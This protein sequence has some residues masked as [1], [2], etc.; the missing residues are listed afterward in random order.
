MVTD[1]ALSACSVSSLHCRSLQQVTE[2]C[3]EVVSRQHLAVVG[4]G[5][6]DIVKSSRKNSESSWIPYFDRLDY[7]FDDPRSQRFNALD[8][9]FFRVHRVDAGEGLSDLSTLRGRCM[10]KL[11][12]YAE[13]DM[14]FYG[15]TCDWCKQWMTQT[16]IIELCE[17]LPLSNEGVLDV[18]QSDG[19]EAGNDYFDELLSPQPG[20]GVFDA[21][22]T[23]SRYEISAETQQDSSEFT[24]VP[25][26]DAASPS[27]ASDH[28]DEN[29]GN[30][31]DDKEGSSVRIDPTISSPRPETETKS[32]K[33]E[34][35]LSKFH[36]LTR[37][38][39]RQHF[40]HR[41]SKARNQ[42]HNL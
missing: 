29:H 39:R 27:P 19:S 25:E 13:G 22:P 1:D 21:N 32:N 2:M 12:S 38:E 34:R 10:Q 40:R 9:A 37:S 17:E 42:R 11:S 4:D 14:V 16:D 28:L 7:P 33:G 23:Q 18:L 20:D 24:Q 5:L 6:G 36:W 3:A 8:S 30:G 35:S 15:A 31:F 41:S 26:T